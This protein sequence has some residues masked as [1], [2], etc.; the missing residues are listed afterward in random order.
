MWYRCENCIFASNSQKV[1]NTHDDKP[2]H[3]V[4]EEDE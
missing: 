1:A 2:G 3:H 4:V